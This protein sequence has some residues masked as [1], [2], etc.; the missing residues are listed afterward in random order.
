[1]IDPRAIA[2]QGL[3]FGP[4]ATASQGML[5]IDLRDQAP[6]YH[7][8]GRRYTDDDIR[9]LVEAKWEAIEAGRLAQEPRAPAA[10]PEP[11]VASPVGIRPAPVQ[12]QAA[13]R[14]AAADVLLPS[15]AEA[16]RLA[17]QRGDEEALLLMLA[18]LL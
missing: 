16:A 2:V 12:P 6:E 3:G 11:I 5:G 7:G 4:L 18:E 17:R 15:A 1:M 9:A 13:P 8:S 10:A 14:D